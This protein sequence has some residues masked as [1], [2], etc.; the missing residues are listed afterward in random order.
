MG[1]ATSF[2]GTLATCDGSFVKRPVCMIRGVNLLSL[3]PSL[4]LLVWGSLY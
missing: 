1:A 2:G 3:L 4:R